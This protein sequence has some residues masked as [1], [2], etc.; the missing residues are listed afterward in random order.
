[1]SQL[2]WKSFFNSKREDAKP[3]QFPRYRI[4]VICKC[5]TLIRNYITEK[6][7][8]PQDPQGKIVM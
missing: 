5:K 6:A 1:M 2:P 4:F 8:V 7:Q 3:R